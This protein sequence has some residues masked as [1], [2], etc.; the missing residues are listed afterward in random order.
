MKKLLFSALIL[1]L[2]GL[3]AVH[4][5]AQTASTSD[6]LVAQPVPDRTVV[7][8]VSD[9]GVSKPITWGLDLAWLSEGNLRRGVDFMGSDVVDVVRSSFMP[10]DPLVGDTALSGEAL[11]NTNY[12]ISLIN[13]WLDPSTQVV[14]NSDH[15]SIDPSFDPSNPDQSVN[16]AKLIEVTKN[17]HEAAGRT[18]VTVSPFNEPDYSVTG[19]G[20]ID[21][22][23][24][25][26][27]EL[28][29]NPEFNNVRI[30]G[31]NTLN[32]DEALNWYSYLN[33]AG[34]TEGNTHQL[35]GDFN[36]YADFYTAVRASGDYATADELHNVMEAMVGVEYGMQT[37]I[38]WG[39]AEY[40]RGEFCKAS[41]PGGARLGYAE[42]RPNWTA[43]SVYRAP[44]NKIQAFVGSSRT[45]GNN[46]QLQICIYR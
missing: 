29:N 18:V 24:D 20:T 31:G 21:D 32:N 9:P 36:H 5:Y 35:A 19:Q 39:T 27:V 26:V 22:F 14:L 7:Y 37:G 34:L 17:M 10:T 38:W 25:I 4:L 3:N 41:R 40:A 8:N 44:D 15:P 16:W 46:Y 13:T 12:R 28:N 1:F 11:T 6:N 33:P 45:S 30:S 43:A 42:H 2:I 23:Y